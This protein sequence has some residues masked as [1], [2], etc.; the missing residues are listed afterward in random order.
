MPGT[1]QDIEQQYKDNHIRVLMNG[2]KAIKIR[3]YSKQ[4]LYEK[5]YMIYLNHKDKSQE[6]LNDIVGYESR[7]KNMAIAQ[8]ASNELS[9]KIEPEK[10]STIIYRMKKR[11]GKL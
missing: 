9:Q 5:V 8:I 4:E 2:I 10:L 11:R 6:K 3:P 7:S 1:S